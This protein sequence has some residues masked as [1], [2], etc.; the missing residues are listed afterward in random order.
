MRLTSKSL[1]LEKNRLLSAVSVG[2]L[3]TVSDLNTQFFFHI[4]CRPHLL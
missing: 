4:A 3:R 1:D 2:T